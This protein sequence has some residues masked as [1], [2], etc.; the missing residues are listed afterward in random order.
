MKRLITFILMVLALL[1][2]ISTTYAQRVS[3]PAAPATGY[4]LSWYS[5]DNGGATS[6]TGGSFTLAG[7][8]GEP[9]AGVASGG[10]Y[11]LNGGFLAGVVVSYNVYMPMVVKGL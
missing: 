8:I 6:I 1:I 5:I 9:D 2:G 3:S 10:S 11:T 7:S 4:E